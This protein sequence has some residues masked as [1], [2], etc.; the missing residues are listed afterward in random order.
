MA[1]VLP[2]DDNGYFA[3]SGLRRSHS[4]S[5]FTS[6]TSPYSTSSHLSDHYRPASNSYAGPNSSSSPSSPRTVHADSV[7]LSYAST[8]VSNLSIDSDYDGTSGLAEPLKDHMFPSFAQEKLSV[9]SE[10]CSN[11]HYNDN[12]ELS[13]SP[14]TDDSYAVSPL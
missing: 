9:H 7:E 11:I 12:L 13:P 6:S 4:H 10:I 8:L 5:K 3:V 14:R 2:L 1:A